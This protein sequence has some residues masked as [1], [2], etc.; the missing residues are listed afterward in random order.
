M[1]LPWILY[2]RISALLYPHSLPSIRSRETCPAGECLIEEAL[3]CCVEAQGP[4]VELGYRLNP[5]DGVGAVER[6]PYVRRQLPLPNDALLQQNLPNHTTQHLAPERR[7]QQTALHLP[8]EI[9]D[10]G[11]QQQ[12]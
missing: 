12:S 5:T 4:A 9:R 7:S 8:N 1:L 3:L 10:R 2:L 6:P 11:L